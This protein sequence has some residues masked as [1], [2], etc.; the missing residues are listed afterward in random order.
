[1][2]YHFEMCN[3]FENLEQLMKMPN[4]NV[5]TKATEMFSMFSDEG[6]ESFVSS[7]M[8]GGM[9]TDNETNYDNT[10]NGVFNI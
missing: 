3:G 10:S 2:K 5:Y 8:R 6:R 9:S 4:Y 7:Q 1:M